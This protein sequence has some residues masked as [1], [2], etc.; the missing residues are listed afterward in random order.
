MSTVMSAFAI[1]LL[2]IE[3]ARILP[4]PPGR[5]AAHQIRVPLPRTHRGRFQ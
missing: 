5:I 2:G 4:A 1:L 3:S